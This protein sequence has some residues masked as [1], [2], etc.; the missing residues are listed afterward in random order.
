MTPVKV[1]LGPAGIHF[2]SA[3]NTVF[4]GNSAHAESVI[5]ATGGWAGV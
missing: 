1:G 5:L 2:L 4:D 3:P